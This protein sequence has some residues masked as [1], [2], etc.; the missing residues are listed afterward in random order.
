MVPRIL[1][2][3]ER[4]FAARP[5]LNVSIRDIAAEAGL[6]HSAIYRYFDGKDDVLRQ[7]LARGRQRQLERDARSRDAGDTLSGAVDWFMR[8]NRAYALVIARAALEGETQSSL[9]LDPQEATARA[10]VRLLREGEFTF[11]LRT[12]HDPQVVAAAVMALSLGWAIAEE[13]ILEATGLEDR[14]LA[15]VREELGQ[16]MSSIMALA[17]GGR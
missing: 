11:P 1:D 15:Q 7:V 10:A 17:G 14:D 3:A 12:D 13:W 5:R 2:A 4:L 6:P 16:I 8:E 9:G